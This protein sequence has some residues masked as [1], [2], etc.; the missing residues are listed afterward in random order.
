MNAKCYPSWFMQERTCSAQM[1]ANT[2]QAMDVFNL[3]LYAATFSSS[4]ILSKNE[5]QTDEVNRHYFSCFLDYKKKHG[6]HS[7]VV[8]FIAVDLLVPDAYNYK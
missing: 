1:K 3:F 7:S 8:W 4:P 5:N 6:L 2:S